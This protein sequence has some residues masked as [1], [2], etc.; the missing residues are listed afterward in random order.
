MRD[1]VEGSRWLLAALAAPIAV[2]VLLGASYLHYGWA[3]NAAGVFVLVVAWIVG[4]VLVL[5]AVVRDSAGWTPLILGLVAVAVLLGAV[6]FLGRGL[7]YRTVAVVETCTV[8]YVG[9]EAIAG[10]SARGPG[11]VWEEDPV[12]GTGN[13]TVEWD[14][15]GTLTTSRTTATR[16]DAEPGQV[17][18]VAR[19]PRGT[20]PSM[21]AEQALGLLWPSVW[22]LA[23][24]SLLA[25]A[26]PRPRRPRPG[27]DPRGERP[28]STGSAGRRPGGAPPDEHWSDGR[29]QGEEYPDD[30]WRGE[31]WTGDR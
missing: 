15:G 25:V 26:L 18:E 21:R 11:R 9:G 19:D 2:T 3:P 12:T 14:C 31:A 20:M 4:V 6:Q 22:F 1:E 17:M 13:F 27:E 29:W 24:A 28:E 23:G 8:T 10:R 5:F 30:G 16:P 7:A